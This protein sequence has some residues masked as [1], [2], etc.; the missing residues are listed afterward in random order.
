MGTNV[1]RMSAPVFPKLTIDGD[2]DKLLA[3]YRRAT[4]V[5]AETIVEPGDESALAAP[6][7]RG[8]GPVM[9]ELWDAAFKT[10]GL[11]WSNEG[12]FSAH[13]AF[14]ANTKG[15]GLPALL[16]IRDASP[17]DIPAAMLLAD[18]EWGLFQL[19]GD[20]ERLA[21]A[22]PI[23][24]ADFL[25]H[26]KRLRRSD[27]FFTGNAGAYQL[28]ATGRFTAGAR[29][30]PSLA[31]KAAWVDATGMF[32][33]TARRI[34]EMA[35]V[36]GRDD[37]R[38]Q[39]DWYFRDMAAKINAKMWQEGEGWY[40]DL[41]EH[42]DPYPMRTLA[43][44]WPLLAGIAT[45]SRFETAVNKLAD[46]SQFERAHSFSTV[47]ASEKDYRR[48]D[49][50]PVGVARCDFNNV[51]FRV[52]RA[53]GR[54]SLLAQKIE[55]HF[56]RIA[57]VHEATGLLHHSFDPDKD[58]A[59]DERQT[60]STLAAATIVDHAIGGLFGVTPRA[61]K[62]EL[63]VRVSGT[64]K[65]MIEGLAFMLGTLNMQIG[66]P[67]K[68]GARREI[69]IMSDLNFRLILKD[70]GRTSSYDITPGLHTVTV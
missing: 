38:A 66:A 70:R 17:S 46:V 33:L 62:Q 42:N 53:A 32:A 23:L 58:A 49:G 56:K 37:E 45:Q 48:R 41:D 57:K 8:E 24:Y 27:G 2:R 12:T 60:D 16:D 4:E 28:H 22:F 34:S 68:S 30:V 26:E 39:A 11:R 3:V 15:R 36:L 13:D 20:R 69:D 35:R 19:R 7:V 67:D 5:L 50:T 6:V 10:F 14:F 18:A 31:A 55:T 59:T 54:D 43:G 63:E 47:S 9:V 44:L 64:E 52:L 40:L 25:Q 61:S 65:M 51:A 1:R 21:H 29:V